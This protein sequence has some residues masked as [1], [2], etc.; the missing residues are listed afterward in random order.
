[1]NLAF[2]FAFSR[3]LG[4]THRARARPWLA[5]R[6]RPR[7]RS[8]PYASSSSQPIS[9]S[10]WHTMPRCCIRTVLA[11]CLH[12][13]G[14]SDAGNSAWMTSVWQFRSVARGSSPSPSPRRVP[15][16]SCMFPDPDQIVL[17]Y[18]TV[19]PSIIIV[20]IRAAIRPSFEVG[21][22]HAHARTYGSDS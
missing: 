10:G 18:C 20:F 21:S 2:G 5:L 22:V 6:L 1:M 17:T 15:R 12:V 16:C 11:L 13:L 3:V 19:I 8:L 7:C 9:A 14:G 4:R